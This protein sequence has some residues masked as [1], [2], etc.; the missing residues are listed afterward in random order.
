MQIL[1]IGYI[2]KGSF[3]QLSTGGNVP[4]HPSAPPRISQPTKIS[5]IVPFLGSWLYSHVALILHIFT[6]ACSPTFHCASSP[7]TTPSSSLT[8]P[9]SPRA[10]LCTSPAQ[11]KRELSQLLRDGLTCGDKNATNSVGLYGLCGCVSGICVGMWV[12]GRV[13]I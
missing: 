10:R 5:V 1:V 12:W 2:Q 4:T 3:L 11:R 7:P 6:C 8:L 9:S 13:W